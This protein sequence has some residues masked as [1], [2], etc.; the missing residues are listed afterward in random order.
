MRTAAEIGEGVVRV[1]GDALARGQIAQ[2]FQLVGFLF[3]FQFRARLAH[4]EFAAGKRVIAF[5][6]FGHA[7]FDGLQVGRGKGRGAVEVVVEALLDGGADR[8][9][10]L[11][12]EVAHG[13]RHDVRRGVP[14]HLAPARVVERE[15]RYLCAVL[16]RSEEVAH[17][18]VH[19]QGQGCASQPGT[20]FGRQARACFARF[21]LPSA[22]VGKKDLHALQAARPDAQGARTVKSTGPRVGETAHSENR[23]L[24]SASCTEA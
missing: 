19:G 15:D 1:E 7:R 3:R 11:R 5:H 6:D 24:E 20:N 8:E 14:E 12:K 18:A 13:L 22:A 21:H 16:Q 10:C 23:E 2:D 17:P 9:T 4:G